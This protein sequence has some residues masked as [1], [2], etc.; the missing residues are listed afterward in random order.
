MKFPG[1]NFS[2]DQE[3]RVKSLIKELERNLVISNRISKQEV[4]DIQLSSHLLVMVNHTGLNGIPSSKLY[5]YLS[6]QCRIMDVN[7]DYDIVDET[8]LNLKT[9]Y[10]C[11]TPE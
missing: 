2:V 7:W 9:G 8:V 3:R 5:D 1:L 6:L 4:L 11:N 10:I